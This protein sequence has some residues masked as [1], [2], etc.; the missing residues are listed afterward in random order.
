MRV[1][2]NIT[3]HGG[4][5]ADAPEKNKKVH[6]MRRVQRFSDFD[7]QVWTDG[8]VVLDVSSWAGALVYPKEGR[9]EKVVL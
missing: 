7:Y 4:L 5:K 2:F 8:S 6:T 9:R 3:T 1:H